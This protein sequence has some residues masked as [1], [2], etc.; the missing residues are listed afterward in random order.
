MRRLLAPPAAVLACIVVPALL[1]TFWVTLFGYIGLAAI[2]TVGLTLLTGISGQTSFGQASFVGVAAYATAIL[3]TFH[4]MPPLVGLVA[5]LVLTG[6][7]A[8]LLG[9]ITARLSG[10]FLALCSIAWGISFFV[11]FGTLPFLHGFNGFGNIPALS[12]GPV[13]LANRRVNV[14]LIWLSVAMA[15]LLVRNLLDS[16][17]G[18]AIRALNGAKLMAESIGVDTARLSRTVFVV[19][20]LFA[21]LSGWLFAHFQRFINPTPFSLTAS[22]EYLFMAIV[23]GT[24]WIGG[25]VLGAVLVT[26]LRDQLNDW[27]PW[28]IGRPGNYESVVFAL[29]VIVLLHR[30]PRG[31]WP[32]LI[33]PFG[34]GPTGNA[35]I[36]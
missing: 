32:L 18:R 26:V 1:P 15:A 17:S 21:G 36:A 4:G 12:I 2:V 24:E 7:I 35:S 31:L 19:A 27:V 33:A 23:G 28:L 25:A 10:H 29:V 34:A 6:A 16:R 5:G 13:S 20:A 22:I 30:A 11:L 8:W 14:A 3:T 9:L